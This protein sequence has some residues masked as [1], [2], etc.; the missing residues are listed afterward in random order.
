MK[1]TK[2]SIVL[3]A[4]AVLA[5]VAF[6]MVFADPIK[7]VSWKDAFFGYSVMG[8]SVK[9]NWLTFIGFLLVLG[10]AVLLC[11]LA[12]GKLAEKRRLIVI[13]SIALL[14]VGALLMFLCG[15]LWKM[16]ESKLGTTPDLGIG[17]I[18]GGILALLAGA[19]AAVSEF[20]LKE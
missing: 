20:V 16:L 15:A 5:L 6:F 17:C 7:H 11:L 4:A 1:L 3:L 12:L 18:M 2:K 19:G 14:A 9:G 10:A 13:I 8:V